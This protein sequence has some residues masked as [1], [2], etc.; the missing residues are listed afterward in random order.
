MTGSRRGTSR[1][2]VHYLPMTMSVTAEVNTFTGPPVFVGGQNPFNMQGLLWFARHV[3][4]EV[5]RR[6]PSFELA[7]VGNTFVKWRPD[8]GVDLR[9]PVDNLD[10]VYAEAAFAIC[11][12]LA[13]TGQQ[14]KILD[15]MAH[16]VAVVATRQTAASS[17]IVDGV[18][19]YVVDTPAAF[20]DRV[21]TLWSDRGLSR[22]LG[23]AARDTIAT[24]YSPSRT[25]AELEAILG[26]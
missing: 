11:P 3:L 10:K 18:N 21:A 4:P 14:I 9:G 1:T 17:P 2:H 5:R 15:A 25:V 6:L 16:G 8:T 26:A 23:D 20:A 7:A 13:G 24:Y 22:V 12:L 19:G